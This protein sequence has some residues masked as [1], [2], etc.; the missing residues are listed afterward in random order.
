MHH[1]NTWLRI[2]SYFSVFAYEDK[3]PFTAGYRLKTE[4]V[5]DTE[6]YDRNTEPCITT[7]SDRI[8]RKMARLRSFATVY[9]L[10]KPR[11]G[12]VPYCN[13]SSPWHIRRSTIS[14]GR[15]RRRLWSPYMETIYDLR[16]HPYPVVNVVY[17]RIRHG[18]I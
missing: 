4:V 15:K 17:L 16:F 6:K 10:R 13:R 18:D 12:M 2:R 14:Y 9:G 8:W 3:W 5:Y 11:P 7:K 1:R